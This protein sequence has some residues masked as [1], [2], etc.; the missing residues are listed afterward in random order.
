MGTQGETVDVRTVSLRNGR[1]EPVAVATDLTRGRL[2]ADD[3]GG[4][5]AFPPSDH[6]RRVQSELARREGV[7]GHLDI[8]SNSRPCSASCMR[9]P[10]V[11]S[12]AAA[13]ASHS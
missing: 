7:R 1:I 10:V 2:P 13:G 3:D 6:A 5:R 11:L 12:A 9:P 4:R 8:T